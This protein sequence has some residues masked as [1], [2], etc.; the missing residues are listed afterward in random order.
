LLGYPLEDVVSFVKN[1]GWD[2]VLCQYWKVYYNP[3]RAKA[4]YAAYDRAKVQ[5][6]QIMR[7]GRSIENIKYKPQLLGSVI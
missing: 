5:V 1:T 7:S 2:Y 6:L 4:I 3:K